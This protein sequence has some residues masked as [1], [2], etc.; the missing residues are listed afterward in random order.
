MNWVLLRLDEPGDHAR[1]AALMDQAPTI[2]TELGMRPLMERAVV[3]QEKALHFQQESPNTQLALP[4]VRSKF[5][6]LLRPV[7]VTLRFPRN[8]C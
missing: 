5:Y 1:A 3:L 4:L 8:S 7:R 2:S 6:T